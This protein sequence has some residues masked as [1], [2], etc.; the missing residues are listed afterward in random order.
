MRSSYS[1]V[2]KEDAILWKKSVIGESEKKMEAD[3]Q[4]NSI[5]DPT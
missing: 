4:L 5:L 3:A 1:Q 2:K